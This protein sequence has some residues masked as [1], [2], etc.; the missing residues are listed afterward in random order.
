[1]ARL[2]ELQEAVQAYVLCGDRRIDSEVVV[3]E[4]MDAQT[5]LDIYAEAYRLRLIEA[6]G[7][8]FHALWTLLGKD[9][10]DALGNAYIEA[11][12]SRY[13]S[14]RYFGQHMAR[15]L[16]LTTPYRDRPWLAAL[17]AFEWALGEAF[18][19]ADAAPLTLEA[20]AAM[21]AVGWPAMRLELHP[22]VRRLDLAWNASAMWLAV[23]Q[24]QAPPPPDPLPSAIP[25]VIWRQGL[26]TLFRSLPEDEA[27]AL[28]S[29]AAQRPFG[30]ICEGL[31]RW[32]L[33]AEVSTRAAGLL[34]QWIEDGMVVAATTPH[35]D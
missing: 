20:M 5:R 17:A 22:S 25:Y 12:P 16:A 30:E 6:L 28:D 31:C 19:A 9:A 8:D 18:D 10:F 4:R 13:F 14:I 11:H 2:R 34:R 26:R 27:W 3:T 35:A 7:S 21:P 24:D 23:D 1:M 32:S 29:A 33:E 15:F